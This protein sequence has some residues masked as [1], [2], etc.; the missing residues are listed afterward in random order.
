MHSMHHSSQQYISDSVR[1]D[2]NEIMETPKPM[3]DVDK[4]R[5]EILNATRPGTAIEVKSVKE[6]R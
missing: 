5:E 3:T 2:L 6:F 1:E 4:I